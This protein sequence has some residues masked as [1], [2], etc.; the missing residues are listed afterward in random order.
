MNRRYTF[1]FRISG[2]ER[3]III[4]LAE[5]LARSRSDTLRWLIRHK[6]FELGILNAKPVPTERKQEAQHNEDLR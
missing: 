5:I 6:A 4:M 2:D 3:R 1:R